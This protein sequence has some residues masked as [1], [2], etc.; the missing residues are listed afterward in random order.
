[1]IFSFPLYPLSSSSVCFARKVL[2]DYMAATQQ[3][4]FTENQLVYFQ[5]A[6][7]RLTKYVYREGL[8]VDFHFDT[9]LFKRDKEI[10][11]K[12]DTPRQGSSETRA[13]SSS[14]RER[15]SVH[16]KESS[17]LKSEQCFFKVKKSVKF[18]ILY[19]FIY[20]VLRPR[21][22]YSLVE[23][24]FTIVSFDPLPFLPS[25]SSP[26]CFVRSTLILTTMTCSKSSKS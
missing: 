19:L 1:M 26:P 16:R 17:S 11:I 15:P 21:K 13:G 18:I 24:F 25:S 6:F 2:G 10:F 8:T 20:L 3:M 22:S 14:E 23:Y 9:Q 4:V 7:T 12:F 5:M